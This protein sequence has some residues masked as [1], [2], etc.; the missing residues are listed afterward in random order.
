MDIS[1]TVQSNSDQLTAED[2]KSGPRIL[3][4]SRVVPGPDEKRKVAI[5]Y[6]ED[7]K[8]PFLPCLSMRRVLLELWGRDS[9]EYTGRRIEVFCDMSVSFNGIKG[10]VRIKSLSHING[11]KNATVMGSGRRPVTYAIEEL[12]T[13]QPPTPAH[14]APQQPPAREASRPARAAATQA[15]PQPVPTLLDQALARCRQAGLTDEGLAKF[16]D[17]LSRGVTE[18][19]GHLSAKTLQAIVDKGI[20]SETVADCNG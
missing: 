16:C 3:T 15:P 19:L 1:T 17:K 11:R 20:T 2:L 5:Y 6:Q 14:Q 12:K 8:H 9:K 13:S 7:S 18:D 10:G 4:V